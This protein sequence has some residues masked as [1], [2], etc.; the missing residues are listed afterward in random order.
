VLAPAGPRIAFTDGADCNGHTRIWAALDKIRT[1]HSD[2]VLL[3]GGSPARRRAHR[4]LL[5]APYFEPVPVQ[6]VGVIRDR[7]VRVLFFV[8][9]NCSGASAAVASKR[10]TTRQFA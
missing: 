5:G 9:M 6:Q 2:M 7:D 10:R 8:I 3:H 1:K 4:R